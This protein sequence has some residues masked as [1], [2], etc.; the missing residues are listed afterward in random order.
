MEQNTIIRDVDCS[1]DTPLIH[2]YP[3]EPIYGK[4]IKHFPAIPGRTDSEHFQ[5]IFLPNL[6][7]LE[8]YDLIIVLFSGGKDSTT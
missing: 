6:L 5:K 7:P 1:P 2:G 4:G 3:D 8:E